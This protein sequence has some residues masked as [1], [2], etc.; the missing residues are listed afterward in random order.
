MTTIED[1][2]IK[3][4][5]EN[6]FPVVGV[7]ASAGGMD[8][9][10]A[11]VK[12][13]PEN[14]GMAFIL[15]QHLA[16][17]Y[18]SILPDL[19]QR[20]T[21]LP[22]VEITDN[23]KVLP[24]HIY[25]IPSNQ[26][27]TAND[28]V[29]QLEQRTHGERVNTIDVFFTSLAEIHQQHAIGVVLSGT[30]SDGT[31]G[32]KTIK[33]QGGITVAQDEASAAY[34]A[35]PKSAV[36]AEVVDF[37]LSPEV[38]P[39]HL[40][41][42]IRSSRL[43]LSD[44]NLSDEVKEE[45]TFRQ[46]ITLLKTK[47][48]IDFTY[49]KQTTIRRRILRRKALSRV[50]S[51]SDYYTLLLE[52]KTEQDALFKDILIPVTAFFRDPKT[53][54]ALCETTFPLLFKDKIE[55]EPIRVWVAG[56]STGEEAYSMAICLH[57]YFGETLQDRKIQIFATDI[58]EQVIAKA[59]SGIYLKKDMTGVTDTRIRKFF[60]RIDGSYQVN[61]EVRQMCV[62]ACHNFLQDPPFAKMDL[63]SCRNVLIYMEPYLQKR[64]FTTFNYAL[65][66]KGFL[67]LGKSE[68]PGQASEQFQQLNQHE[69]IYS[70]KPT[71]RKYMQVATE[72]SETALKRKDAHLN[73][74]DGGKDDFGKAADEAL[75]IK[76]EP[77]GVI[78][79]EQL[80]IVQ[81]RGITSAYLEAPPGKASHNILKMAREG[82]AFE[83]RN[84]LHKAKEGKLTVKKEGIPIGKEARSVDIEIIPL[85]NT[86]DPY[87][88][89][90]FKEANEEVKNL[91]SQ[92]RK[93]RA[94]DDNAATR[95]AALRIAYLEKELSQL[96]EDMRAITENQEAA[97]EELQSA[98]EELL[99]GSEELQSLNE[100]LETSKE[101]IQSSNEELTSLNQELLE[102]N[103]Q[104]VY[105]RKYAE[106]IV[107]TMH[108]PLLVLTKDFQ[109]RSANK[110]FYEK[111]A[112][113][114]EHTEGQLFFEWGEGVWNVPVLREHLQ[115]I[116]PDQSHLEQFEVA[117]TLPSLGQR[118]L[119]LNARPIINDI[120]SEQLIL[121]ALQDITDKKAFN[122]ALESQVQVRTQ[123]LQEA[124]VHLRQLNE[125]LRQFA[126]IASHDLQEPLRKIKT[127]AILLNRHYANDGSG[128]ERNLINKISRAADRMSQL[129]KEV[130]EYSKLVQ[131]A[132]EYVP[133][134]L[135]TIL[136]NVLKD[137]ELLALEKEAVVQYREALPTIDA[138]PLQMNQLFS[139]LLSNAL[140]FHPEASKPAIAISFK[141]LSAN[142]LKAFPAKRAELSYIE[143][144]IE[145]NGIGFEPEFADQIFQLFERL[146]SV[147][148]YEGTGL[149][150]ALCKKIV[151]NHNGEIFGVSTEGAGASFYVILPVSQFIA[152]ESG[153]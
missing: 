132:K 76:Y 139:N 101:E 27:L 149:G 24:D 61:K 8:A 11:L 5:S 99:S 79:N 20:V 43:Q 128:E 90:L 84:A 74:R 146:H 114:E 129:I 92:K 94:K 1:K 9:F 124:N 37:V 81:F 59:R 62:F 142:E 70:R 53:F 34:Y 144:K 115:K 30:G 148:E 51:L 120:S 86:I 17:Q 28:G 112:T 85:Q 41:E 91:A 44:V 68:T 89:V 135:D 57:E 96:R 33:D 66:D 55:V 48:S 54:D 121:L 83:L 71:T 151:E 40:L 78:I 14:S 136:R 65:N 107:T 127:F 119:S 6:L 16:P 141:M 134:D 82:L 22:V 58:S 31:L 29:L 18:E 67:L 125:N 104:L 88:L 75:L 137:L 45:A 39:S 130:L 153:N 38:I 106:A 21:K 87:F 7:G 10:K 118:V 131:D 47:H 4:L 13:I 15:I 145:D 26:V 46:I 117:A 109:I 19:L 97:N 98:N 72:G 3:I 138:I 102:R 93:K 123:E 52:N 73:S 63:I 140:K 103:E 105:A 77:V 126:S 108:E 100:E 95:A 35:M 110:S 36:D 111:F 113:T 147:D 122:N 12:A 23:I 150:L 56:C 64:A 32:L 116:L 152:F 60:T 2:D 80:D 25:V 50:E 69:K 143:I 49:Y 42:V 133:T